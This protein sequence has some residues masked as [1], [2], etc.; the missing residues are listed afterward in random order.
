LKGRLV[1]LFIK[2]LLLKIRGEVSTDKLVKLGLKIGKNFNRLPGCIIDY[3]HCWLINIGDNVT[4]APRVHILAHDASTKLYSNYT[5]IGL[6]IIGNDV[7][8]GAGT[9]IL[10]NVKIGNNVIIGAG[11]VVTNDIPNN[12]LAVGNP[13]KVIKSMSQYLNKNEEYMR[14]RPIFNSDWTINKITN[15]QKNE[16]IA[17][18]KDGIGYIE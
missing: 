5:K 4:L 8:I 13:A 9:V 2:K 3:S 14:G 18:L 7:F 1:L 10:P 15:S 12:S 11:S 17:K 16:M 6:V